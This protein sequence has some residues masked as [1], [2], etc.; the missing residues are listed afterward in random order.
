MIISVL[1]ENTSSSPDLIPEHGLSLLLET[2]KEKILFDFGQTDA[3][4]KNA[5]Q[6][7]ISLNDA[8]FAVLSHGHYDHGG[9]MGVFLS[10]NPTAPVYLSRYAFGEYYNAERKYIGLDKSLQRIDRMIP[11]GECTR[12]SSTCSLFSCNIQHRPFGTNPYGLTEFTDEKYSDDRFLHEQ[13]LLLRDRGKRILVSGCSHK[14]IENIVHWFKPDVLIGGFHQM[15]VDCSSREGLN[16]LKALSDTLLRYDTVFY[17]CHCTGLPQLD[18]LKSHMKERLHSL[19]T[20]D[21][22]TL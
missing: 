17:T 2:D 10:H 5:G 8:D 21:V 9:G 11:T 4:F 18:I 1:C 12:I 7:G 16:T 15:K 6:M 22:I 20:G 14:G 19:S 3:F 13:Y